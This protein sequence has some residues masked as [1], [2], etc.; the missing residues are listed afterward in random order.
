[1]VDNNIKS[2]NLVIST[3]GDKSLHKTWLSKDKNFDLILLYYGDNP[4]V[5]LSYTQDTKLVFQG[6]GFKWHLIKALLLGKPELI[7]NYD[8]IWFPDDDVKIDPTDVNKLFDLVYEYNLLL[9]QPSMIGYTSHQITIPQPNSLLRYTNFV[10]VLA[11]LM[12][13]KIINKVIDTFD[14]NY[15]SWGL[16]HLWPY[17]LNYPED[18][19]AIVD[20]IVME[21]TKP[22]GNP[23]L[24]NK[25]PHPLQYDVDLAYSKFGF[26]TEQPMKEYSKILK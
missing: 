15:S 1:M 19:I 16:D 12:S 20:S 10:E 17:L 21:H 13:T 18:K 5:S 26:E 7:Q 6:K 23:D 14:A 3:V 24:Y 4:D 25:I 2:K 11:P 22:V 8:Y 9:A